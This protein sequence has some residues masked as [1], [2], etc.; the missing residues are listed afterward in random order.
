M[1]LLENCFAI[2]LIYSIHY[3]LFKEIGNKLNSI[4]AKPLKCIENIHRRLPVFLTYM[5][6]TEEKQTEKNLYYHQN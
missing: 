3:K 5:T 1:F 6:M 4:E 2:K